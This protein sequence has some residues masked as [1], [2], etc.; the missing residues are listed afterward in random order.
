MCIILLGTV[1]LSPTGTQQ[2]HNIV[3]IN[4]LVQN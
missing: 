3:I 2:K 1:F 4:F